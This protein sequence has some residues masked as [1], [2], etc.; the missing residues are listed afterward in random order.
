MFSICCDKG[1]WS[2]TKT[3]Q[4]SILFNENKK[5]LYS[6]WTKFSIH[7]C[8]SHIFEKLEFILRTHFSAVEKNI[9]QKRLQPLFGV[10]WLTMTHLAICRALAAEQYNFSN[11]ALSNDPL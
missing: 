2:K 3:L 6:L 8:F 10:H 1:F 4:Y 9:F 5:H 11:D 7:D